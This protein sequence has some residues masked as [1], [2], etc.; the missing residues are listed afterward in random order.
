MMS[1]GKGDKVWNCTRKKTE[2]P[3]QWGYTCS[4]ATIILTGAMGYDPGGTVRLI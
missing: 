2:Q 1:K 4:G 3:W